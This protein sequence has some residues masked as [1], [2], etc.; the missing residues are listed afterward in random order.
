MNM[1][2]DGNHGHLPVGRRLDDREPPAADTP[3]PAGG[4][5]LGPLVQ[6]VRLERPIAGRLYAA[7]VTGI[8]L[9]VLSA[10]FGI[11]PN[12]AHM[13]THRQLG[14]P[15]CGFATMTR[16]PCPTCGMTTAYAYTVRGRFTDA[17]RAQ[18]AGFVLALAT[19]GF[20]AAG[21][22]AVLTGRRPEVNWYRISPSACLCWLGVLLIG[23]WAL[24]MGLVLLDQRL[25]G[26]AG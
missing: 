5:R 3:R 26:V 13:G 23:A 9:A 20:A 2:P 11:Q 18:L 6:V 8:A 4:H 10:A 14:L 7:A 1:I 25:A 19:A 17:L 16:L 15:A 22:V 12:G 21:I 24:K